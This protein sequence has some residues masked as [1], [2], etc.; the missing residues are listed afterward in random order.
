MGMNL[1]FFRLSVDMV[2]GVIARFPLVALFACVGTGLVVNA[3][4]GT[5]PAWIEKLIIVFGVSF[6]VGSA[7]YIFAER[8]GRSKS[9]VSALLVIFAE[10]YFWFLPEGFGAMRSIDI[11]QVFLFLLVSVIALF[12]APYFVSRQVNGFWQYNRQLFGRLFFTV[13]ST[14]T[15]FVGIVASLASLQFLF[16]WQIQPEWYFRVWL[17]IVGLVSTTVF[18]AGIPKQFDHLEVMGEYPYVFEV[19]SK[20]VLVPLLLLYGS[21]LYLYGGKILLIGEWPKGTVAFLVF[22]YT[23]FGV[24]TYFLLFPRRDHSSWI[25]PMVKTFFVTL[26][27]LALLLWG[28]VFIRVSEYGLT[29]NRV[30]MMLFGLWMIGTSVFSLTRNRDDVR[31]LFFATAV[32]VLVFSF[33]PLSVFSI[34]RSSQSHRLETLLVKNAVLVD[35]AVNQNQQILIPEKEK[36]D[37]RSAVR[38]LWDMRG[39]DEAIVRMGIP[40][41]GSTPEQVFLTFGVDYGSE[42]DD[43]EVTDM[44]REYRFFTYHRSAV[45]IDGFSRLYRFSCVPECVLQGGNEEVILLDGALQVI[46]LK[47]RKVIENVDL[48]EKARWLSD[49][50]ASSQQVSEETSVEKQPVSKQVDRGD[51]VFE[52]SLGKLKIRILFDDLYFQQTNG[53][54]SIGGVEGILLISRP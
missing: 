23:L 25:R 32:S 3:V 17:L 18:L 45:D 38:Y 47:T 21:I 35:G 4:D 27:P 46:D 42:S 20:Y 10:G 22:W 28:A 43:R 11:A 6:F 48:I 44:T 51:M 30:G 5:T 54:D 41:E 34:A 24:M 8:F 1:V 26:I 39:L 49:R 9:A 15:L 40:L 50:Y 36:D 37:I 19:F 7:G 16:E 31:Y 29:V 14:G 2:R 52:R 53:T 13:F 33:G 12:S